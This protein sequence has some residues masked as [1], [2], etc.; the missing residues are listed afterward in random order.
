MHCK[1]LQTITGPEIEDFFYQ[2]IKILQLSENNT[3]SQNILD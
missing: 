3:F 1:S 2:D